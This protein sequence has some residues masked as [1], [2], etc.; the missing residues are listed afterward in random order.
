MRKIYSFLS[1]LV[2]TCICTTAAFADLSFTINVDDV[3]RVTITDYDDNV[4]TIVN[5]DNVFT[6]GDNE[7]LQLYIRPASGDYGIKGVTQ[8]LADGTSSTLS[9]SYDGSISVTLR[10]A[11]SYYASTN[12]ATYT[13]TSFSYE[14]LR[15]AKCTV[16]V[17]DAS[18]VS[19]YR[20][21][22]SAIPLVNGTNVVSFI[23]SSEG[24]SAEVPFSISTQKQLYKL[25]LNGQDVTNFYSINAK[26]GDVLDIEA[27]W[28]NVDV[29]V[30]FTAG[31]AGTEAFITRVSVDGQ[32]VTNWNDENFTVKLGSEV[33]F[34]TNTSDYAV[35]SIF[36]NGKKEN[37]FYGYGSL[38]IDTEDAQTVTYYVHKYSSYTITINIDHADRVT[39]NQKID[40]NTSPIAGLQDGT[41]TVELS[42]RVNG[43][44]FATARGGCWIESFTDQNGTEYKDYTSS[45]SIPVKEGD[46]FTITTGEVARESSF[47]CY[48]DDPSQA[49]YGGTLT[50]TA[51][52][53][54]RN[55]STIL[56]L[57]DAAQKPIAGGY[58][59]FDFDPGYDNPLQIN[60]YGNCTPLIYQCDTLAATGSGQKI[61]IADK[62]VV[63]IFLAG[64]PAAL[65]VTFSV[66]E[67]ATPDVV[68]DLITPVDNLN[69]T[70]SVFSG[71]QID[72]KALSVKANGTAVAADENGIFS[73]TITENT[74]IE[75]VGDES[76][77]IQHTNTALNRNVY[78]LQGMLL[79]KD[80]TPAQ[81]NALPAGLYIIS[82]KT[83]Y[84]LQH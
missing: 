80:A 43:L 2:A 63:K 52:G 69:E 83:T 57:L 46:V 40:Y 78:T 76:T 5:G 36:I 33:N 3:T 11:S 54:W 17:D 16:N 39:I 37:Y 77:S 29:P 56:P 74:T 38:F 30:H 22:Y 79:I 65:D 4:K 64:T 27:N 6:C 81:I 61:A 48:I 68:R 44:S 72:I 24:Y 45:Q 55:E 51:G 59:A 14:T 10:P 70:L 25:Q 53:D 75:I 31:N 60:I 21:N 1:A 23:P 15:T 49:T 58:Y 12:G 42:E 67:G 26:D 82:G 66:E 9:P 13:V 8:V 71:T 35:D 50:F 7:S 41:N 19:L 32:E 34:N 47:V 84:L 28:P 73:V 62:D 18:K 20:R